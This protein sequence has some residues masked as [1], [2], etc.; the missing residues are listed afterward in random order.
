MCASTDSADG[1][2]SSGGGKQRKTGGKATKVRRGD[3]SLANVVGKKNK[4]QVLRENGQV[5]TKNK[6][7]KVCKRV[8]SYSKE[9]IITQKET[10]RYEH[11]F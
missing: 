6:P 8:I 7:C 4:P 9:P 3:Y 5:C 1:G 11:A 10:F 2:G